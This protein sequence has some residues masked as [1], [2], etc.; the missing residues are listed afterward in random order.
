MPGWRPNREVTEMARGKNDKNSTRSPSTN[1][2]LLPIRF[3][4]QVVQKKWFNNS[5]RIQFTGSIY[6]SLPH[7]GEGGTSL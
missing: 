3:A 7:G 1:A 2:V 4:R 6:Y 5:I